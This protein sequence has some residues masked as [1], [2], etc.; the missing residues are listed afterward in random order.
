MRES[1]L[2][3]AGALGFL[4]EQVSGEASGGAEGGGD[5]GSEGGGG[6]TGIIQNINKLKEASN[7]FAMSISDSFASGFANAVTSGEGFLK[8]MSEIFKG[9]AKQIAAMIIKASVLAVLFQFTGLGNMQAAADGATGFKDLLALGLQGKATGGSVS[10]NSPYMVGEKGP[11]MFMPNS[12][13]TIIPNHK[14]SGG[15][16]DAV[17]PDVRI[18]G[19][20]LL[21]V[22]DRAERRKNRR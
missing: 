12:S 21:I 14:L 10:R 22:F 5:E 20:D 4:N 17:I 19:N 3:A 18:S 7:S 6:D 9:I 16:G 11:E 15:A 8:S 13:G 2:K 1:A